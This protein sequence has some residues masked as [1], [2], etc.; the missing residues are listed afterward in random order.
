MNDRTVF[1]IIGILAVLIA[2]LVLVKEDRVDQSPDPDRLTELHRQAEQ[3]DASAQS[4]LGVMYAAGKGVSQDY[5]EAV[6]WLRLA[7]EQGSADA[8]FNLG[9]LYTLGRGVPQD[10]QE[11]VK[12][13]RL[14]AEQGV[15]NAQL[16]LGAT[17]H[18]GQGVLRDYVQAHKWFNLGTSRTTGE[19]AEDF[20]LKRDELAEKMTAPQL[21]EAQ[22]LAREWQPKTWE[23]LKGQ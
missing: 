23:Q 21:A 17:Y 5:Q 12:W 14:A 9:A 20:R 18:D 16:L 8:Q 3:G 10:G 22:R 13:L 19:M 11:A 6:K 7:A 15:A 1:S 4:A 2:V